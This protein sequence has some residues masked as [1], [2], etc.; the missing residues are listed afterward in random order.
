MDSSE[1]TTVLPCLSAPPHLSAPPVSPYCGPSE[2]NLLYIN[3]TACSCPCVMHFSCLSFCTIV[4]LCIKVLPSP[5]FLNPDINVVAPVV[6]ICPSCFELS[7]VL[8]VSVQ[9]LVNKT[10]F[11]SIP[12]SLSFRSLNTRMPLQQFSLVRCL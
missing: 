3:L 4:S 7:V 1:K 9:S 5:T 6:L 12:A 10:P 11:C 8:L 2:P